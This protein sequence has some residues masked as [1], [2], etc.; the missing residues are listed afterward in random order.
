MGDQAESATTTVKVG[1]MN[2]LLA[3]RDGSAF[4]PSSLKLP[5]GKPRFLLSFPRE[6]GDT[7]LGAK[8]LVYHEARFGYEPPTRNLI[9]RILRPGDLFI[10]VGA[11]WGFFSLQ[12]ASHPA[13]N[14]AVIAFEPDPTNAGIL[15]RNVA[16]NGLRQQVSVVCAACGDDFDLA[17]LVTNSSMMHSIHGVGLKGVPKGPAHW[18]SVI[19]LDNAL[20][21]FPGTA[22]RRII[23]K[24]DAEGFEPKVIAGAGALLQSG[25]VAMVIW[26]CGQA[27][28]DGPEREAMLAMV[29]TLDDLGFHHVRPVSDEGDSVLRPFVPAEPYE[30][31]VF[32]YH[33]AVLETSLIR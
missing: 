24:I 13:G 26:E 25:R 15:L 2:I 33:P 28:A 8:Y 16:E 11:H 20:T 5:D 22:G 18:V 27:F 30:A 21:R 31:N 9:E 23:L 19:S 3:V 6:L 10:D 29:G 32:S 17:P 14:I 7:D 12:A 1:G 4:V